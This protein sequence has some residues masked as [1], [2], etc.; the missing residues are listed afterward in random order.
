MSCQLLCRGKR[1][2]VKSPHLFPGLPMELPWSKKAFI[3]HYSCKRNSIPLPS[4]CSLLQDSD[5][6]PTL[7]LGECLSVVQLLSHVQLFVTWWTAACQAFLS[8]TSSWNLIKLMSIESVMPSNH[9]ILCHPLLFP[10]VFPSIR[11]FSNQSTLHIR[12]PK[13]W[14]F[15]VSPSNGYSGLIFFRI[16]WFDLLVVQGTLKSLL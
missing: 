10:S 4:P 5:K 11:V 12:W 16:D 13:Y 7:A 6:R 2:I 9:L 3:L 14:S 1:A 15:S 8:F